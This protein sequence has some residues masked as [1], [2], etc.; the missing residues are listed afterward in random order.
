MS[1]GGPGGDDDKPYVDSERPDPE[2]D[3]LPSEATQPEGRPRPAE[4][5]GDSDA[6]APKPSDRLPS[7][8][9]HADPD[10]INPDATPGSG[11]LPPAGG[12]DDLDST[13]G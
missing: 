1:A 5:R 4:E 10:L 6:D 9:P 11:A 7:A 3:R 2:I 13:S 12:H 8:G